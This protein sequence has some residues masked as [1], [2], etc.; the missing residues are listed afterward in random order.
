[1]MRSLGVVA[2]FLLLA[3]PSKPPVSGDGGNGGGT[4]GPPSCTAPQVSCGDACANLQTDDAHCGACGIACPADQ[5]CAGGA[6]YPRSCG[7][8]TCPAAYVC[9]GMLC[10]ERD[11]FGVQCPPDQR[12]A[13]GA[14]VASNCAD[15]TCAIDEVCVN[16][17]CVAADC[18]GVLCPPGTRCLQGACTQDMCSDG[19]K[20]GSESD[21][22]CGGICSPCAVGRH[23]GK[24]A[25]CSSDSC[26]S[27]TCVAATCTDGI[28]NGGEADVDCGGP[29]P[30]CPDGQRCAAAT[31]CKSAVCTS[32]LCQVPTCMDHAKNGDETDV[33]C[34]GSCPKCGASQGCMGPSDC[35]SGFCMSQRCVP[36]QCADGMKN[37]LETAV[38]CGGGQCAPCGSGLACGVKS[39]CLS[40]VCTN[41]LCAAPTCSDAVKNGTE[42][43]VDCGGSCPGCAADAGC[44]VPTDCSSLKCVGLVC[45]ASTCTD[46]LHNGAEADVDCGGKTSCPRCAGNSLCDA[47]TDCQSG[48]CTGNRCTV[49]PLLSNPVEYGPQNN[50]AGFAVGDLDGDGNPDIVVNNA[51]S[52]SVSI[53][54]GN[55]LGALSAPYNVGIPNSGWDGPW[56]V[57]I[58]EFTGDGLLDVLA[59]QSNSLGCRLVVLAGTGTRG[60]F[61]AP[62]FDT[63]QDAGMYSGCGATMMIG[64]VDGDALADVVLGDSDQGYGDVKGGFFVHNSGSTTLTPPVPVPGIG[65]YAALHDLNGDGHLD[66]AS[67]SPRNAELRVAYGDGAGHFTQV[68]SSAV[69]SGGGLVAVGEFNSDS[70]PDI[71]VATSATQSVG[72]HFGTDA[73]TWTSPYTVVVN[74]ATG[75][76][77]ADLDGDGLDDVLTGPNCCSTG[78]AYVFKGLGNGQL[79][80]VYNAPTGGILF[81]TARIGAA[82]LTHDGKPELIVVE[83]SYG[84][85]LFVWV[86]QH[87]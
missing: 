12:C 54:Y 79:A 29:C 31:D 30:G 16:D 78:G 27:G 83:N 4:G 61:G 59:A 84:P 39:D 38:D 11:C 65:P 26:T 36:P 71:V 23:C 63:I 10:V 14:C 55:G 58:L 64:K 52:V 82:D 47:G 49:P 45:Q 67:H 41:M 13:G 51:S 17:A 37:G 34:G 2:A 44:A 53:F 75:V 87:P 73:G 43:A 62:L 69:Q 74:G 32:N 6:C 76:G 80:P 85:A 9:I 33:D 70:Y 21:I 8:M 60:I 46:Q 66:I 48:A 35:S 28:R 15:R 25:D 22:D 19:A 5:A 50:P 40:G 1:M 57:G 56:S 68:F 77:A 42:T 3:C 7:G 81:Q 86:N 20:N 24:G 72:I 18:I